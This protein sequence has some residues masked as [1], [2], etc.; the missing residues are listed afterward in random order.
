MANGFIVTDAHR[1]AGPV[2]K[3]LVLRRGTLTI[4]TTATV[5]A[6][7]G[8]LPASMFGFSE[9]LNVSAVTKS[10]NAEIYTAAIAADGGSVLV[11]DFDAV[12]TFDLPDGTYH[13]TLTGY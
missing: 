2:G 3:T 11:C 1:F 7:A 10:D 8:D 4:D 9:L 12:N 6:T 5:G 13:L